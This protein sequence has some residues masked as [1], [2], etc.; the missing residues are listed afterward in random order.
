MTRRFAWS[1]GRGERSRDPGSGS[2][3]RRPGTVR[4]VPTISQNFN[5]IWFAMPAA[6]GI[7]VGM[8]QVSA[9]TDM[10]SKAHAVRDLDNGGLGG[11]DVF[12]GR[13]SPALRLLA[14]TSC[15]RMVTA[16]RAQY[17]QPLPACLRCSRRETTR[18]CRDAKLHS[19][20]FLAWALPHLRTLRL[21]VP[22]FMLYL[23]FS[24][25]PRAQLSECWFTRRD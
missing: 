8:L 3:T 14:A 24:N 21:W 5:N 9:A 22:F 7:G 15:A 6:Q 17:G 11:R 4:W 19:M 25:M 18:R 12:R 1:R 23:F 13:F 20:V 10:G 16:V 2:W